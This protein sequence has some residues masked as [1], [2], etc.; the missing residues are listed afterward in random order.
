MVIKLYWL[1]IPAHKRCKCI[2]RKSCSHFVYEKTTNNGF[3]EGIKALIF[4]FQNCRYGHEIFQNPIDE[5][6]QMILPN[7]QIIKEKDIAKRLTSKK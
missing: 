4:R 5:S 1:I 7:G 3:I 6:L 2:F